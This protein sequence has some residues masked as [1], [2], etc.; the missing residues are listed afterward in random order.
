MDKNKLT[1]RELLKMA[2][3]SSAGLILSACGVEATKLSEPTA[4]PSITPFPTATNTPTLTPTPKPPTMGELAR[5][6]GFDVGISLRMVDDFNNPDYQTFLL[7]FTMLTD[8][9][10]SNPDH[11]DNT[12][13]KWG[14][15]EFT[16]EYWNTLSAFCKAHNMS[17]DLNHLYWG[18][19]D[20]FQES[21]PV[22]YLNTAS[23]TEIDAWYQNRVRMF[24]EIPYFTSANFVNEVIY[25]DP[26]NLK[27]GWGGTNF[28]PL[29]RIYGKDYPYESYKVVWNEAV[30]TGRE[31]GKDIHL[32]YNTAS[33]EIN[34]PGG[35]YE[36]G[37]LSGLRDKLS[38]EFG[39]AR[40]FDIGMQFH[41][42]PGPIN[43]GECWRWNPKYFEKTSL[44]E[45]FRKLGEIGDIRITEFSI[46]DIQDAQE[47]KDILHTV[48]EA[49]IDSGF[50][51]SFMMWSPKDQFDA[52]T[53]RTNMSCSMRNLMYTSYNPMFMFDELYGILKS[54]L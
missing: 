41:I 27:Y 46:A 22:Y 30:R 23:K 53:S 51:K 33:S 5:R 28:D 15:K 45:R 7:N 49:F 24:F 50:G 26:T 40:P 42:G 54:K 39:I 11:T 25:N 35:D 1:R 37:Y 20:Y 47:Q 4:I 2:G 36:Y 34:S 16:M 48:V 19:S 9:W 32:I 29:N 8:G 6:L 43:N 31:V 38:K 21:S 17:L 18:G 12:A 14:N 44:T 3:I 10:A 13:N 52:D